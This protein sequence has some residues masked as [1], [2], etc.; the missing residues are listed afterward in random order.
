MYAL[1]VTEGVVA[2]FRVLDAW[3]REELSRFDGVYR[4]VSLSS[5]VMFERLYGFSI[6]EQFILEKYFDNLNKISPLEHPLITDRISECMFKNTINYVG[7]PEIGMSLMMRVGE[8]PTRPL[9]RIGQD[10]LC[11]EEIKISKPRKDVVEEGS[12]RA[13]AIE[14]RVGQGMVLR[15]RQSHVVTLI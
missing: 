15:H 4:D 12:R 2:D 13:G 11:Q 6:P 10:R 7:R 5:R 3:H 8:S 1:R 9:I 14:C